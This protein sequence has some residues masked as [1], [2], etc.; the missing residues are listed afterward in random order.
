MFKRF[1]FSLQLAMVRLGQLFHP[2]AKVFANAFPAG[3]HDTGVVTLEAEEVIST[4]NLI[5]KR[6]TA[7]TQVKICGASDIPNGVIDDTADTIGDRVSVKLLGAVRGTVLMVA[8]AEIAAGAT[9]VPAAS[10][11]IRALP[12]SSGTYYPVGVAPHGASADGE[13]VEVVPYPPIPRVV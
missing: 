13:L 8:S 6:G 4:I 10:G 12:V 2:R 3:I 11:K 5:S 9:V 7:S 1:K